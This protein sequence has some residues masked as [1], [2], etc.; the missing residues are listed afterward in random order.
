VNSR[1]FAASIWRTSSIFYRAL[2]R[3]HLALERL[4]LDGIIL[5]PLPKNLNHLQQPLL[6]SAKLFQTPHHLQMLLLQWAAGP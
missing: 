4:H 1:N 5:L 3:L 6:P 2:Q